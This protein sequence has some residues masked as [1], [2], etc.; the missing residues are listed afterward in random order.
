[1]SLKQQLCKC[2]ICRRNRT[3]LRMSPVMIW[4]FYPVAVL[5]VLL[6]SE[7]GQLYAAHPT[8][9]I[10]RASLWP[11]EESFSERLYL[12][13]ALLSLSFP[14]R[15]CHQLWS[16]LTSPF[17]YF[18]NRLKP[19]ATLTSTFLPFAAPACTNCKPDICRLS[20]TW[21]APLQALASYFFM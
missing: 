20:A 1:M 12:L 18:A 5:H 13:T 3:F 17:Q 10:K 21:K 4:V 14:C 2:P 19:A 6:F 7:P 8:A 15:C 16:D 9:A 11:N